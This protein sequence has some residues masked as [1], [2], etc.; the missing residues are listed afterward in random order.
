VEA[1]TNIS[2][3]MKP[4]KPGP[5]LLE[6]DQELPDTIQQFRNAMPLKEY[7]IWVVIRKFAK[8]P[9]KWRRRKI[10]GQS[11]SLNNEERHSI[12]LM[13]MFLP[14]GAEGSR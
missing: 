7:R 8:S 9:P 6:S 10:L 14:S 5:R 1:I 4:T 11:S 3:K 13:L 2:M 12:I